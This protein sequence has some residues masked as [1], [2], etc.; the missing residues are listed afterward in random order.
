MEEAFRAVLLAS[1]GVTAICGN[2]IDFG[3]NVQ[4]AAFPRIVLWTIGDAEDYNLQGPDGHSIGR[5][6]VDCYGATY[7][8]AKQLSRAVRAVL[9]GYSGGGFQGVFLA[10]SRDTREG[11]SNEPERPFRV[12]LDFITNF[13]PT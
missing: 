13:N 7:L 3:S 10:G 9:D 6:Q 5:V 1:S 2:R 8:S 11:G 12:S 4:G